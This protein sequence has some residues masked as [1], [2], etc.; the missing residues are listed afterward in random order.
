MY[1]IL[2]GDGK[3]YGPVNADQVRAWIRERRANAQTRIRAEDSAGWRALGEL[4]EFAAEL[5]GT[6]GAPPGA[7]PP[8]PG[9]VATVD[10]D[11]LAAEVLARHPRVAIRQCL[12]RGWALLT[13]RF[14]L[15]V[16]VCFVALLVEQVPFIFG[17]MHTGLFWF[18]LRRIRG[19]E[20]KFEDAFAAFSVA[21]LPTFL[22]GIVFALLVGL[23]MLFCLIPGLILVTVWSFAWPLLIDRRLDFWPAMELSRKVLWPNFWGM[24]GLWV[25][26]VLVLI[27]GV[28]CCYVGVFVAMPVV[29]AAQAY[30]YEDFFGR[31]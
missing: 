2:G 1:R 14:W 25:M 29:I 26:N 9:G 8:V 12:S 20:A 16:G 5:G 7:P 30:A 18:F 15:T 13:Q 24:F 10:I 11:A 17:V 6:A 27:A 22:G 4:P 19:E 31:K 23:G 21:F 28:L 3:E